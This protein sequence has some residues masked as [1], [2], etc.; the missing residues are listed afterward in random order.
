M[1]TNSATLVAGI[2]STFLRD[3]FLF[4]RIVYNNI[5][6]LTRVVFFLTPFRPELSN[7][8]NY[9]NSNNVN[10]LNTRYPQTINGG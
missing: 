8:N 2:R 4:F 6:L 9:I 5:T 3:E 1:R 7:N 10:I